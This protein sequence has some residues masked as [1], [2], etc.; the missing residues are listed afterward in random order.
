[1]NRMWQIGSIVLVLGLIILAGLLIKAFY[2]PQGI[3]AVRD[4]ILA[5]RTLRD[6]TVVKLDAKLVDLEAEL[7]ELKGSDGDETKRLNVS[8]LTLETKPIKDM[9]TLPGVVEASSDIA[10]AAKNDGPVEFLGVMEGDRVAKGQLIARIDASVLV[11]ILKSAEAAEKLAEV[12]FKRLDE[13]FK[14]KVASQNELDQAR[15]Q[16]D[17]ARAAME[18][19]RQN[20]DDATLVSPIDGEV[21]HLPVDV[22]E[23]VNRGQTVA[24]IVDVSTVK[25]VVNVPEKDV[26]FFREAQPVVVANPDATSGTTP[27]KISRIGLVADA[28]A[29]TFPVEIAVDNDAKTFLPGMISKIEMIRR[30]RDEAIVISAFSAIN[31]ERGTLVYVEENGVARARNVRLGIRRGME[32]EVE[33]GLQA[34]ERLI[35]KG[36]RTLTDGALVR[37]VEA[38]GVEPT[39]ETDQPLDMAANAR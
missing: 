12:N 10:L 23:F 8:V 11:Q 7:R 13:L 16:L 28:L 26:S 27:G 33:S 21:D 29:K 34:G 1:M 20:L 32:F 30:Q 37:V 25:L 4:E 39:A 14:R 22:G 3:E 5:T 17:Q 19:A 36:H 24:R 35:V 6:Q 15:S 2:A 38:V 9:L 18:I 31:T